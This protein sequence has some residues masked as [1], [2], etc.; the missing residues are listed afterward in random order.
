MV[1]YKSLLGLTRLT[2][3]GIAVRRPNGD[4]FVTVASHSFPPG[5]EDVFHPQ[6]SPNVEVMGRVVE[7]LGQTD[8]ALMNFKPGLSYATDLFKTGDMRDPT[9]SH[10]SIR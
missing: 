1:E 2:S 9:S 8:I 5:R 3:S 6:Q 10:A 7:R 4:N